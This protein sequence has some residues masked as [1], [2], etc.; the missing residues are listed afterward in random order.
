MDFESPTAWAQSFEDYVEQFSPLFQR[1]ETRQSVQHYLRGLLAEVKRK[2]TW[3]MAEVLELHDPHPLQRVLNEALWEAGAVRHQLRQV[4]IQQLGY[5]PG[6]G[7]IDESGFVKWGDK[8]AGVGPQ[9]CGRL[10]KVENCQVGVYLGYVAPTG[11]AFLDCRLYLPRAWCED[12]ARCQGAKIPDTVTFQTKPQ[13]AQAMLEQAWAEDIPMQWVVGDSLYGNSPS[14]RQAI[15]HH[16]RAYVLAIGAQ[17]HVMPVEHRQAVPLNRLVTG[18]PEADWERLC[19]RI[20][21]KGL[22]WY[23]WL[24][25]RVTLANDTI[26]EQWLLIQRT[27]GAAPS[28]TFW[29]SNAPVDTL[30]AD[31]AVVALSRHPIEHL[32]EEAKGQVG[33]ADYEVRHWHGWHRHMALVMM[34]HTWLKLLQHDQREKKCA[35]HLVELQLG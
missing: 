32:L 9:Y 13:I 34:A 29:L 33:M 14:L 24:A 20:G 31:L 3:Q 10:G 26:G 28:Y 27:L 21:E 1:S 8:S 22:I 2:N 18:L 17:H 30:I 35:A 11:A 6:I 7:I 12:R 5:K 25:L 16:G 19:F 15:Q 23:E 4:V